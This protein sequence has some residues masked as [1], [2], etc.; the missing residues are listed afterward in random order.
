MVHRRRR[1]RILIAAVLGLLAIS[2]CMRRELV[3]DSTP[4]GALVTVNDVE[5][6]RTPVRIGFVYYGTYDVRIEKDGFEPLRT[7]LEATAPIYERAPVD[8]AAMSIPASIKTRVKRHYELQPTLE[9]TMEGAA[10]EE[11]IVRR[12]RELGAEVAK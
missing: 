12:A 2:G 9:R 6:G 3:I 11:E 1:R 8:F 5:V 7:K 4:S 10:L